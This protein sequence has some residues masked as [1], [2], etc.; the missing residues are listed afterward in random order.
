MRRDDI[1][2]FYIIYTPEQTAGGLSNDKT[3]QQWGLYLGDPW[4]ALS[5][6]LLGV[7]Q[8]SQRPDG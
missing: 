2:Y 3:E 6:K 1:F 5:L 7:S 8:I 4:S